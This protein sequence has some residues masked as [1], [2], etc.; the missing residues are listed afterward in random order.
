MQVLTQ[1]SADTSLTC[2]THNS[3]TPQSLSGM[4]LPRSSQAALT[5]SPTNRIFRFV[6]HLFLQDIPSLS[7]PLIYLS[8]YHLSHPLLFITKNPTTNK[9]NIMNLYVSIS[10]L[11]E[12]TRCGYFHPSLIILKQILDHIIGSTN[13]LADISKS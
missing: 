11:Q 9:K 2:M 5:N 13:I 4:I 3:E 8:T 7:P 10:Q 6:Y 1:N 12:G